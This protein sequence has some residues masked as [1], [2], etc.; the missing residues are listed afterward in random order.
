[1]CQQSPELEP[2]SIKRQKKEQLLP[3]QVIRRV[4]RAIS[5]EQ[6]A[7]GVT[8]DCPHTHNKF[9]H[10]FPTMCLFSTSINKQ[11]LEDSIGKFIPV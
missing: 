11:I 3:Y 2:N 6:K 9:P 4:A 8:Q 5:G 10:C 1:V 7:G